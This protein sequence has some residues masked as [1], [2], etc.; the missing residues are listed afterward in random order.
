MYTL[1]GCCIK[2]HSMVMYISAAAN[3]FRSMYKSNNSFCIVI[4]IPHKELDYYIPKDSCVH[5]E[6]SVAF[7]KSSCMA[8]T[9]LSLIVWTGFFSINLVA[10]LFKGETINFWN[11]LH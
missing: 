10:G 9:I 3:Y 4:Y 11:P 7:Q 2:Y 5:W 8:S 6:K 1:R